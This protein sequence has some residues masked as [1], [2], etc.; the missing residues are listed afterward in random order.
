MKR[1]YD[2]ELEVVPTRIYNMEQIE[3]TKRQSCYETIIYLFFSDK[4]TTIYLE[5]YAIMENNLKMELKSYYTR[6]K[7]ENVIV[8]YGDAFVFFYNRWIFYN[9]IIESKK[10]NCIRIIER[11]P[12]LTY[13]EEVL[14]YITD[15]VMTQFNFVKESP[16]I[17]EDS[18]KNAWKI[19]T[20]FP[21][22]VVAILQIMKRK[23]KKLVLDDGTKKIEFTVIPKIEYVRKYAPPSVDLQHY[24][25]SKAQITAGTNIIS[26]AYNSFMKQS[27]P[28]HILETIRKNSTKYENSVL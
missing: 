10:S 6:K 3:I 18:G 28:T 21:Y 12:K 25:F 7:F 15:I 16:W 24:G 9:L 5:K 17:N 2:G 20:D 23:G 8:S 1:R 26:E 13:N 22:F 14:N 19:L 4:R 11:T 27:I